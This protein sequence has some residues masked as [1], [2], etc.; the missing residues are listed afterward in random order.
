MGTSKDGRKWV[1]VRNELA[2]QPGLAVFE[3]Y[4]DPDKDSQ[5]KV[6][7]E[8]VKEYP[9]FKEFEPVTLKVLRYRVYNDNLIIQDAVAV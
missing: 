2:L 1:R 7:N 3:Q 9:R 4:F 5:I 8:E 6:L